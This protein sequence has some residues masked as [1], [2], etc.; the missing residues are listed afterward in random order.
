MERGRAA[1]RDVVGDDLIQA[2]QRGMMGVHQHDR[3][4]GLLK[5]YIAIARRQG[6]DQHAIYTLAAR[7]ISEVQ[8]ALRGRFDVVQDQVV[9]ALDEGVLDAAQAFH[10]SRACKPR[11][12]D[13]DGQRFAQ[14][15]AAGGGVGT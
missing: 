15:K 7:Y 6:D 1:A 10:F 8:I 9:I 13:G 11:H 3:D 12:D 2:G 5:V 4:V 14:R